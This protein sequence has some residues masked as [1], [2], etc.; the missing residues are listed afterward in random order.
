VAA[1][2]E[3]DVCI[4]NRSAA[5]LAGDAAKSADQ[6]HSLE[7]WVRRDRLCFEV[8]RRDFTIARD[9]LRRALSRYAE[10]P[11]TDWQFVTNEYG[12][13]SIESIAPQLRGLSSNLSYTRGCVECAITTIAPVGVDV[14]RSDQSRRVQEIA[15]WYFSEKEAARLR[16]CSDESSKS[17]HTVSAQRTSK[18]SLNWAALNNQAH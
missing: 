2:N 5:L 11:P 13:P 9:L 17:S 10:V 16:Q 1:L 12:K 14:E 8:D 4:W 18:S 15:N 6:N 7:E 3:S